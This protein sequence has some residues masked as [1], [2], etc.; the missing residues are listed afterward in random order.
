MGSDWLIIAPYYCAD[1]NIPNHTKN[2]CICKLL[3]GFLVQ[4]RNESTSPLYVYIFSFLKRKED[5]LNVCALCL[6]ALER[7]YEAVMQAILRHINFDG[8]AAA[9]IN[10][11]LDMSSLKACLWFCHTLSSL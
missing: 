4:L 3:G 6:Q 11:H 10:T 2:Y 9:E 5:N 1:N 7:F 8:S